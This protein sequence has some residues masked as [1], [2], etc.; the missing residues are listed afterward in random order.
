MKSGNIKCI[1]KKRYQDMKLLCIKI[2][3]AALLIACCAASVLCVDE[4]AIFD[5]ATRYYN[6]GL[7]ANAIKEYSKVIA[8]VPQVPEPYYYRGKSYNK[9]GQY[10]EAIEDFN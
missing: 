1:K 6:E 2:F 9:L 7:Y 8:L 3:F 5:N 4:Q 10:D